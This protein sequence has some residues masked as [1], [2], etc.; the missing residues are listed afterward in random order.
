M[1]DLHYVCQQGWYYRLFSRSFLT[2]V[3]STVNMVQT[4]WMP[5]RRRFCRPVSVL[6]PQ[7]LVNVL[8]LFQGLG[9]HSY[10]EE[11]R[12]VLQECKTQAA[13]STKTRTRLR[14]ACNWSMKSQQ[15]YLS[16]VEQYSSNDSP[17]MVGSKDGCNTG[18]FYYLVENG[19][20]LCFKSFFSKPIMKSLE[21]SSKHSCR[22]QNS[23]LTGTFSIW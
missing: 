14:L 15:N 23:M 22:I 11:V 5:V 7:L 19:W 8:F 4:R 10:I 3:I 20:A 16:C 13:V 17:I 12:S 2:S 9:F 18:I 6:K 1:S 21:V